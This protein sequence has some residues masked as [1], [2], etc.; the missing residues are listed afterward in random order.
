MQLENQKLAKKL[1]VLTKE[2]YALQASLEKRVSELETLL[3]EKND[4]LTTYEKLE[5][6][7][8]DVVMQ[9]AESKALMTCFMK[10]FAP[11]PFKMAKT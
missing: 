2:Y 4:K 5:L 8:D 10:L 3:T 9:S 11:S 7:L 1:E 6:E